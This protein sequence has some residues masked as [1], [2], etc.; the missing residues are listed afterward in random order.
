MRLLLALALL[1]PLLV[2]PARA[3]GKYDACIQRDD[4]TM[5]DMGECGGAWIDREDARLNVAWK[6]LIAAISAGS[7]PALLDEQRAWLAF[8]DKSCLA[9]LDAAEYGQNGRYLSYPA[10]RAAIIEQRTAT[11]KSFVAAISPEQ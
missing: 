11:L 7:K 3:D 9:F 4:A 1:P 5:Q 10:C 8:R 2:Q 6:K